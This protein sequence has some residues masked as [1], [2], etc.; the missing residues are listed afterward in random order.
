MT[1]ALAIADLRA[2]Y[3]ATAILHGIDLQVAEAEVVAILG[4]N[5][6]GKTTLV[7]T[8]M[9]LVRPTSGTV[10]VLGA[11]VTG[12]APH[13]VARR[14]VGYVPQE[15]GIFDELTVEEN[16]RIVLKRGDLLKRATHTAFE[17]FPVLGE[18]LG[19]AAGTLS[20]GERKMLMVARVLVQQ[21]RLIILDEVSEGVQ[22]SNVGQ[23]AAALRD[24]QV[25]GAAILVIEQKLDFALSLAS[26]F[27][28]LK[29]GV[30]VAEGPV[31]ESTATEVTRHLVL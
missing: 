4:R 3:G 11:D 10:S 25:R 16:F 15:G 8:A 12:D 29:H 22:P 31:A 17:A 13:R 7:K 26:R 28:V 19:Q 30:A 5:G 24:E 27:C 18:R 6:V 21:P 2:G 14:G 9:G 23:I 20:G 1:Q